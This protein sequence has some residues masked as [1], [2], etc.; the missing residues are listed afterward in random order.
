MSDLYVCCFRDR[1][2]GHF[3]DPVVFANEA[4]AVRSFLSMVEQ[5]PV[6]SDLELYHL[7]SFDRLTGQFVPLPSP[8]F[9]MLGGQ[10]K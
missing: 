4:T 10:G 5:S 3:A 8:E 6:G 9:V 7:G 2:V 1:V